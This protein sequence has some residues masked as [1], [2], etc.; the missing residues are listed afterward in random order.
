MSILT[1]VLC[2]AASIAAGNPA[3]HTQTYIVTMQEA[4]TAVHG[5]D[6]RVATMDALSLLAA[7]MPLH[8]DTS[9]APPA[10]VRGI[11]NSTVYGFAADMEVSMVEA[12]KKSPFV[13]T[14][15]VD[16]VATAT[17]V[18]WNLDRIDQRQLPLDGEYINRPSAGGRGAVVYVLD[19][20]VR[21]DHT[22][23]MGTNGVSR[24]TGGIDFVGDDKGWNDCNGHGT[25]CAS[26]VAGSSYGVAP[27]ASIRSV[28]VL[29]CSGAGRFSDIISAI[30][31]VVRQQSVVNSPPAVI[32]MSLGGGYSNTLNRAV[33]AAV[34]SGV[35]V[36]VASGNDGKDAC[37]YSPGSASM[38]TT[39]AASTKRDTRSSFSNYGSC[40]DIY[41][42]GSSIIGADFTSRTGLKT[43]SGTSMA[44][45]HVAGSVALAISTGSTPGEAQRIVLASATKSV[46]HEANGKPIQH[47]LLYTGSL[48]G[49]D[50]RGNTTP[51]PTPAPIKQRKCMV[52]D[53]SPCVFPFTFEGKIHRS[54]TVDHDASSSAWCSTKTD[55]G[56]VH[57]RGH[58]GYCR[59]QAGCGMCGGV[60]AQ[61]HDGGCSKQSA[62]LGSHRAISITTLVFVCLQVLVMLVWV[63]A[64]S[65]VCTRAN[66]AQNGQVRRRLSFGCHHTPPG[67]VSMSL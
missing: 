2:C 20:G 27:R 41:A 12:L 3:H 61:A 55:M 50:E 49:D 46:L 5:Y 44:C 17:A 64:E 56:G 59:M 21:A 66:K 37:L 29:G 67:A 51:P 54:C 63:A 35:P 31:W 43:L 38:A 52:A 42:P 16:Q 39:V 47:G 13:D 9:G 62:V 6:A 36:V 14:V 1:A 18:P 4:M 24:V 8:A 23:F 10:A 60:V 7:H 26:T 40:V 19:T 15:E 28:R 65:E 25:H 57:I 34:Q 32:S 58:W 48:G 53:G 30:D 22:E 45:P 33:N 11:Y